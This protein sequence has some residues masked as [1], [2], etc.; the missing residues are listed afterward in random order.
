MPVGIKN[1]LIRRNAS[2]GAST[3]A[4]QSGGHV[5]ES[6]LKRGFKNNDL[7]SKIYPV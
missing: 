2:A 3:L 4:F 7:G 5:I 1:M 6:P